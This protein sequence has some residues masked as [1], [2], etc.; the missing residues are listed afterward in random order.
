[1]KRYLFLL[2]VAVVF[3]ASAQI[4]VDVS[5]AGL[6][7]TSVEI[8]VA[9]REFAKCLAKNLELSGLFTVK[10]G[11]SVKVR[12]ASGALQAEGKG[13]SL[14]RSDVFTDGKSARMAARRMADAMCETFEGKKGFACDKIVFLNRSDRI[15][16]S[17]VLPSELCVSY[18]D[19]FDI[20]QLTSDAKMAIFPR[21]KDAETIYYISDKG[22]APQ[23]WQMNVST[24][25]RS[26]K[27]SF[28]GSPTGIAVSPDGASIAAVLS[29]QGNPELYV[30]DLAKGSWRRL[31]NTPRASEGQPAWSP[32]GR[33]IAYVSNETR[34]P[35]IYVVDISSGAKRR[36]TSR[37]RENIDPDWGPDGRIAYI[38]KRGG[39]QV[40]VMSPE[41]G[42]ASAELITAEASWEHPSWAR[43]GRHLVASRDRA[44]FVVDTMKDGDK[45][46]QMF[47]AKG[48]WISPSWIK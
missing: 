5:G 44:I 37:G 2:A 1:M 9:D 45:P 6:K 48:N 26:C 18:P 11:G 27:F 42:D 36:L 46:R 30:I 20:R 24:S 25:L 4:V 38:T 12:G 22:G 41:S 14:H 16:K 3:S 31:T 13:Q 21:W 29:F 7:K 19:G 10:P 23:I 35:Q 28:K 40:A 47:F 33:K 17:K 8:S 39:A 34:T 15:G 43:D 32:D